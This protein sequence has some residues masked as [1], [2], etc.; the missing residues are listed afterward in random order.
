M[1]KYSSAHVGAVDAINHDP[2]SLADLAYEM[3]PL[4]WIRWI[5]LLNEK[6]EAIEFV[7]HK[8]LKQVYRDLHPNQASEKGAQ[9]GMTETV[10]N[11][12]L[13]Y[14]DNHKITAI[15]T[16]PTAKLVYKFSQSRFSPVIKKNQYLKRRM[17]GSVDNAELKHIGD[18][19]I[20]FGGAQ[21]ENQA[22]SVPADLLV[23]DEWDFSD[24]DILDA[25]GK[26]TIA[27]QHDW[28]WRFS[29]PTIPGYG[30]DAEFDT[31]D[32]R[33]WLIRCERCNTWQDVEWERNVF[34]RR[35]GSYYF[36][37]W[38]CHK[39]LKRRKGIWVA[40]YPDRAKDAIYNDKGELLQPAEGKRGYWINPLT[41]TFVTAAKKVENF[42][43]AEKSKKPVRIKNFYNYELGRPYTSAEARL[44]ESIIL[45]HMQLTYPDD[46]YN[47]MGIDQGD[48]LHWVIM[49][50]S[51][52]ER[53]P[54]IKFGTTSDW[55]DI[56]KLA[57]YWDIQVG[58]VDAMPNKDPARNLTKRQKRKF[59]MCY[60][61]DQN[62]DL[63]KR[64]EK[65][66][67]YNKELYTHSHRETQTL[68]LDRTETIDTTVAAW[69][70]GLEYLVGD[71]TARTPEIEEFILQM[72]GMKRD[73]VENAKGIE[74]ARWVKVKADH[75]LHACNYATVAASIKRRKGSIEDLVVGGSMDVGITLPMGMERGPQALFIPEIASTSSI[76]FKDW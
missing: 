59:W 75:F 21:K 37:C 61:R 54:I 56:D 67:D 11:K 19:W 26:R 24:P 66:N 36:G 2:Y 38:K 42:K 39:M 13:W 10:I 9:V 58:V 32:Q 70:E 41:F 69:V 60:Y 57:L 28:V 53:K 25:Y 18:S 46:G 64:V 7:D 31:T 30:I 74:V 23:H 22:I 5:G 43:A 48:I 17:K 62:A 20:H 49:H 6:G 76:N 15:Y 44:N 33:H 40:L 8:P 73:I 4:A 12:L 50:V 72:Q 65:D 34:K 35:Y 63:L 45:Q 29:T 27:S 51:P 71:K 1:P 14:G 47:V 3:D 16:M 52:S 68:I 55:A